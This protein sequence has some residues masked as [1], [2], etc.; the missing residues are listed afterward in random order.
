[1]VVGWP[2]TTVTE[3]IS[4]RNLTVYAPTLKVKPADVKRCVM[5]DLAGWESTTY[6]WL[7]PAG[8]RA[9]K[10]RKLGVL[11]LPENEFNI[12]IVTAAKNCF[13]TLPKI[14]I[15]HILEDRG[16]PLPPSPTLFEFLRVLVADVLKGISQ[17]DLLDILALRCP[18]AD[19]LAEWYMSEEAADH[20]EQM[21]ADDKNNVETLKDNLSTEAAVA[22]EYQQEFLEYSSK[23]PR[24]K[25]RCQTPSS[26][27]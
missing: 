16:L 27:E 5:D 3:K 4:G 6:T 1:M 12:L 7:S 9:R 19:P 2:A 24:K 22:V 13:W 15:Q 17:V 8:A 23:V 18:K 21:S 26:K 25:K 14:A 20:M 11:A 10:L